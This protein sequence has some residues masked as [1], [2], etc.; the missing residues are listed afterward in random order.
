MTARLTEDADRRAHVF[1]GER[2]A[3]EWP[4]NHVKQNQHERN[5]GGQPLESASQKAPQWISGWRLTV[6]VGTSLCWVEGRH[7]MTLRWAHH[8]LL[9]QVTSCHT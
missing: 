7:S 4:A 3:H 8:G 5:L 9:C 1:R 6:G 2:M